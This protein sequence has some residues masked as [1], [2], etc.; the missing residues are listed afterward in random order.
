MSPLRL[1]LLQAVLLVVVAGTAAAPQ[2]PG[3]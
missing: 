2:Q 1:D 3:E